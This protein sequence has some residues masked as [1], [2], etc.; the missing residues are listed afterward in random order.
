MQ[1]VE[2]R[3]GFSRSNEIRQEVSQNYEIDGALSGG[4]GTGAEE[5]KTMKQNE[6]ELTLSISGKIESEE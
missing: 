3:G 6:D 1:R 5:Q 2:R 4:A